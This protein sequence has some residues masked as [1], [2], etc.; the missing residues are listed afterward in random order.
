MSDL[1]TSGLDTGEEV[2][3]GLTDFT[4]GSQPSA[5]TDGGAGGSGTAANL[6]DKVR[7]AIPLWQHCFLSPAG[8]VTLAG[9]FCDIG[10]FPVSPD[11]GSTWSYSGTITAVTPVTLLTLFGLTELPAILGADGLRAAGFI[12]RLSGNVAFCAAS[13]D[14]L[15]VPIGDSADMVTNV[16]RYP[17]IAGSVLLRLGRA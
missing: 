16:G 8:N 7:P 15:T 12:G 1:I 17:Q 10:G 3:Q 13:Q 2:I 5:G 14:M 4:G 9:Y 6:I 11:F